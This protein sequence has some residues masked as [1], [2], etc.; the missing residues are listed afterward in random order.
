MPFA[1]FLIAAALP[2]FEIQAVDEQT[3]RGVPMVE[4]KTTDQARFI[5][6]SAGRIAFGEPGWFDRPVYFSVR[7]HG[8]EVSKDGFGFAGIR[9]VPKAGE[10]AVI[11]LKRTNVAERLYRL[12][13]A[14]IYR[15][16]ILLGHRAP[17][18][19]ALMNAEVTGQDSTQSVVYRDKI[20]W[21]WGDTQRASYAL[22]LFRMA[23]AVSEL[24]SQ[25]GLPISTGVNFAYFTGGDGF[26]RAMVDFPEEEGL[27][28]LDGVCVLPGKEGV[29][30]LLA[31]YSRRRGL[32]EEIEHGL[33][34]Y[35]DERDVF[36]RL[37]SLPKAE[38]WRFPRDHPFVV[39]EEGG[40]WLYIGET[41]PN[42]RVRAAVEDVSDPSRYEAWTSREWSSIASPEEPAPWVEHGVGRRIKLHRGTVRWNAWR[43]RWIG[44]M[45]EIG[46]E[47]SHLGEVW[48]AEARHPLGPWSPAVRV[49][50]HDRQ[51]FYN[52]VHHAHF[53][54]DG[55][56]IIY[57]EGTYTHQFSG[58]PEQTPRYDYNQILYRLDLA[59]P[60]LAP[61]RD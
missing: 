42:I 6:D 35:D 18:Q 34:I 45:C 56:R 23:G 22:G 12:T 13:G 20:R 17:I 16:S 48:Y 54:E 7:S 50:T 51:T 55:G 57:F 27:V 11:R 59:D 36:V 40:P 5:T 9:L 8:Y 43:Q 3:E 26:A 49:V 31:H 25:G 44:I 21:F 41:L 53:D 2:L 19:Q 60:R 1:S 15:D 46:G 37:N 38:K 10:R 14:G 39:R 47:A 33:A 24:P 29:E 30:R 58:N 4:L 61:A 28:W 52:P 32:E